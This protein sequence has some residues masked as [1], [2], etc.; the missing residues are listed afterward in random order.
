MAI[1][2]RHYHYIVRLCR[3]ITVMVLL[4]NSW[5]KWRFN[6]LFKICRDWRIMLLLI[7][8][9]LLAISAWSLQP[10]LLVTSV[11]L[12]SYRYIMFILSF[13]SLKLRLCDRWI[14]IFLSINKRIINLISS[15]SI[16][17]IKVCCLWSWS[18]LLLSIHQTLMRRT[19][20]MTN[21]SEWSF[22]WSLFRYRNIL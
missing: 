14:F 21:F 22:I 3:K 5:M 17:F 6:I 2:C 18:Q 1:D 7:R 20:F 10:A 4:W 13:W 19:C 9:T 15:S 12:I 16:C 11:R 8:Y